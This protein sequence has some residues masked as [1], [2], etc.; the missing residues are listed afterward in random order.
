MATRRRPRQTITAM[1]EGGPRP[2][3]SERVFEPTDL[4]SRSFVIPGKAR[5][6]VLDSYKC[7][8]G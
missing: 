3:G 1:A 6:D 8:K 7:A 5:D 4:P 2:G